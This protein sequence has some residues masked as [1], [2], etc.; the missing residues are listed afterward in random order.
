MNNSMEWIIVN[1]SELYSSDP[2]LKTE[3]FVKNLP[4]KEITPGVDWLGI[5]MALGR[6]GRD[7]FGRLGA[8]VGVSQKIN[9]K[10][11]H[12]RDAS[13]IIR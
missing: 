6:K 10:G 2:V 7:A 3:D 1:Q 12:C 5:D 13:A 8:A 4:P 11:L 9:K